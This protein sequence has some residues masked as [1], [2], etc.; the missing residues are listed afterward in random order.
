[1][2]QQRIKAQPTAL[3]SLALGLAVAALLIAA[4]ALF[5]NVPAAQPGNVR[6]SALARIN[7][8]GVL[9]AAYGGFPPYTIVDPRETDPNKRVS[10][11][12][13]DMINEIAK[14]SSPSLRVE[15]YNLNWETFRSDI[16]SDKFDVVAD[17]VYATI[18][19]AN[20]FQF[21]EPFSYFGLAAAVVRIDDN[22]FTSFKD[23]DRPDIVIT[24]A[25]GYVSNDYAQQELAK[26]TFK[27][28]TV[29]KDAFAQLDE[30]LLGHADVALNDV[31]TIVQ[32]VRAHADKVK[33][34][35]IDR[36]PSWAAASFVTRRED[37]EL[38]AALSTDIQIMKIDGTLDRLDRKWQSLG[39]F[40]RP[41][42]TPGAGLLVQNPK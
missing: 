2:L 26:P 31:P 40:D 3:T 35:W 21:T 39:Y 33:G 27:L 12:T 29:G 9:R 13:V 42:M 15:W 23:L 41:N 22:R 37:F 18:P 16:L 34:L 24:L 30:V 32:Y 5:R 4:A 19:K 8:T 20:D 10:G 25:Q 36:P 1:M 38:N 11:F 14:R 7:R 17:A 6:E 28:L